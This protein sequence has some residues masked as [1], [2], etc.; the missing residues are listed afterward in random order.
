M[1]F[2]LIINLS[3]GVKRIGSQYA[4]LAE[5]ISPAEDI[6]NAKL[7]AALMVIEFLFKTQVDNSIALPVGIAIIG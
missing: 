1:R 3:I 4:D 6:G 5:I 7:N 2:C